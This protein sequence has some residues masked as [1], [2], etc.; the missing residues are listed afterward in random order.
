A[1]RALARTRV[2][3]A[4]AAATG[5]VAGQSFQVLTYHRVNDDADP[6]F[7][8]LPT[9]VFERHMAYVASVYRVLT[10]EELVERQAERRVPRNALAITFDDGYRDTLTHAAPIL[11]RHGLPATVFVTTGCI[12][13][14]EIPWFDVLAMALRETPH[15]GIVAPWGEPI[16]LERRAE[17][18]RALERLQRHFKSLPEDR[19]APEL[20][21]VLA[22]LGA[23]EPALF[24]DWMLSW[25]DVHAL[26][27]L[28]FSIGAHT[29][30]HPILSRLGERRAWAEIAGSRQ[31]IQAAGQP[32]PR[33]FAYPN[34][35][36]DDY[37][38]AVVRL[39]ERAGFRCAVTTRG[40]LN[41]PRT[42]RLEL[43]RGGPWEHDDATFGLKLAL[44][45]LG[46]P[47]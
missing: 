31:A 44:A 19:F 37:T 25:E 15:A 10:V 12:G 7:P 6:F 16:G 41:G 11:A 29:I 43:R 24:K 36:A 47:R 5:A 21:A 42:P 40:G 3:P 35:G 45:R 17:R 18:T 34:G 20:D 4:L 46:R 32:A 30:T 28:G 1:A 22:A 27:G 26:A 33:A 13:T 2:L 39:V 23:P 14:G 38:P 8:A 9:R